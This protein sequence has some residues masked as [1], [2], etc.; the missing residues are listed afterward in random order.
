[1]KTI[2]GLLAFSLIGFLPCKAQNLPKARDYY[3]ELYAAGGLDRMA[4][5]YVCFFDDSNI[6]NFFIFGEGK[7]LREFMM[8]NGTFEKLPKEAQ[9]AM[10]TDFLVVRGYT[11][12]VPFGSQDFYTKDK[13]SWVTEEG[14]MKNK[15]DSLA[16]RMRLDINWQTLRFRRSVEILNPDLSFQGEVPLFGRCEKIPPTIRQHGPEENR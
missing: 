14:V 16:F 7:H 8:A 11:K 4:D 5:G 1:M 3:K 12:G 13:D 6:G 2:M 10:K 15:D 9:A